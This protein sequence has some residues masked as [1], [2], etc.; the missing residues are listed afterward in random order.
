VIDIPAAYNPRV[1]YGCA[2]ITPQ[3]ERLAQF[4]ASAQAKAVLRQAGFGG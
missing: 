4:L 1:A 2:V 3:A